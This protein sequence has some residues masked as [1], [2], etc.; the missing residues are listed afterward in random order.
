MTEKETNIE[1]AAIS[2]VIADTI[3][4]KAY[5]F[6]NNNGMGGYIFTTYEIAGWAVEFERKHRDTNWEEVLE[7]GFKKLSN[8]FKGDVICWDDAIMDF[9]QHKLEEAIAKHS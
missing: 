7:K 3:F 9:A 5:D 1:I 8:E 6:F 2:A 4:K